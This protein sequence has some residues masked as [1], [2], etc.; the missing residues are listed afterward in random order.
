MQ[1]EVIVNFEQ[2]ENQIS[3]FYQQFECIDCGTIKGI[4]IKFKDGN[5]KDFAVRCLSAIVASHQMR[6]TSTHNKRNEKNECKNAKTK[7][8]FKIQK[9]QKRQKG[10]YVGFCAFIHANNMTVCKIQQRISYANCILR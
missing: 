3:T 5:R 4:Q 2:D 10:N 6:L 9:M 7:T 1:C 8:N